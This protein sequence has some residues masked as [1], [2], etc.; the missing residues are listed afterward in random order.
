MMK[1]KRGHYYVGDR[2]M[3]RVWRRKGVVTGVPKIFSPL[4]RVDVEWED[5]TKTE[6]WAPSI[7]LDPDFVRELVK[8]MNRKYFVPKVGDRVK[9]LSLGIKGTVEYVAINELPFSHLYPIQLLLDKPYDENG[10]RMYRVGLQEIKL[11][12]K[13]KK[14]KK[15]KEK[16]RIVNDDKPIIWDED[17][18][19]EWD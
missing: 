9:V 16:T 19:I 2:V 18:P 3:D 13:K 17:E 11:L 12:K 1:R 8:Q 7:M 14:P 10:H 5:G 15:Q 6:A 4:S